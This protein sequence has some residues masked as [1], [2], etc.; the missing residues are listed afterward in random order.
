MPSEVSSAGANSNREPTVE[1]LQR[2][3]AEARDQQSATREILGVMAISPS[4]A[5]PVF[6]AIARSARRLCDGFRS[7]VYGFDGTLIHNVAHDN[8]SAEGV[9]VLGRVYPRPPSRETQIA[10]AILEGRVV[11]VPDMDASGVPEQS[12]ALARALG[13]RSILAVPMLK[14]GKS[15]GA[16]AIVRREAGAFSEGQIEVV[17][18][19]AGEAVIA[20]ENT[21][22]FQAEQA[23]KREV[24]EALE[25]QTA[26]SDVLAAIS[27]SKF[28]LQPVLQSV[29]ETAVRLCRAD[30]A[31]IY[32]FEEGAYRF[33]AG[34][35]PYRQE[36]LE[37]ERKE[38]IVPGHGTL[39]GRTVLAKSPVQIADALADPSYQK[40]ADALV[41]GVRSM[42]GVPLIRNE[43]VVGVVGLVRSRV[44]PFSEREV[45]LV[46]AFADQ[47]VIAIE[48]TRL[49]EEVQAR[50]EE[51]QEALERQTATSEVLSAISSSHGALQPVF[52]SLLANAVRLCQAK[53]GNLFIHEEGTFRHVA[54]Y[55]APA[56]FAEAR[57][58]NPVVRPPPRGTLA[59]IAATKEAQ[60][61]PD[62]RT[63]QAYLDG[64]P[65]AIE[66]ADAAGARTLLGVPILKDNEL[67]GVI[68][69]YRQEVR[70]FTA[71]QIELIKSFANQAVIAI[72][73]TRLFEAERA[74]KRELQES[75]QQQTATAEV[76][77]SISRSVFDL[78]AVLDALVE[79]AAKLC[80]GDDVSILRLTGNTL[81]RVA[82][83]GSM[84]A[85]PAYVIPVSRGTVAGRSVIERRPIDV[86][87]LQ[88]EVDTYP[89]GSA[90]ARELGHRTLLVVPLLREG[91]PL[92]AIT[93]RR[94]RVEPFSDKQIELVATFADQAVIAIENT[95]LFE[96]VQE[97]TRELQQSLEYQT[98]TSDVLG[99]ISRSPSEL[100][101]VLDVI[102]TTA[103]KLC[104]GFDA[105]I[106]LRDGDKLRVGAH[107]GGIPLDFESMGLGR[108]WITGR[109]VLDRQP[110][111]VHDLAS[112]RDQF[113]QG[114]DLH[115]RHGHRTGLAVP[116]MRDDQAIG[117]F[118]IRRMDVRPFSQKQIALLQTFADQ[119]VIAIENTR[120]FEAE[121]ASK[122]ELQESL[123]YQ[124]AGSEV[125]NVISRSPNRLQPV[126]DVIAQ[127]ASRLCGGEYAIVTRYDGSLIQLV[128]QHNPR[129]GAAEEAARLYP[130]PADPKASPG[131]RAI[132]TGSLVHMPDVEKE[133]LMGSTL[134]TYRR[135][136]A[137]AILSVP[138]LHRGQPIGGISVSRATPGPFSNRQIALLRTF[139]D[140][141][142]I[143]IE[144]ARLFEEVQ[145][146]TREL[147]EALEQQTATADVLKVISRSALDV[148]KVLDALVE[149]AARLC[150]AYDAAILQAVGDS[151]R[152]VAHYGQIPFSIPVG[153]LSLPLVR[154]LIT[155]RAILDRR[156]IQIADILAEGDEFPEGRRLALQTGFRTA[157]AVPLVHA[158]E[159]I[160]VIFIRR[161][162]VRPFTERQIE[163]VNTFADQAVIAIENTRLFEEVQART[164]ELAKTVED[165]EIASQHKSQ[166]VANMSHELRTPLAAILGYAELM[167]EGF[168][169]PLGQ[170]SL[171]ALTR[172]RS[173]GKH[174]LGLINTVL[175]VA[176]IESGQFTL[177][178]AEYAI[179]SVVETVRS[180]TESLAQHKRLAFKTEIARPL[181]IGLGD[182][183]RLT[184][185]LLNLVGNAI[186][187]T[188]AGEVRVTAKAVNRHFAISVTDTGPG[189][190]DEERTRIFEQFHQIDNSSTKAKGGTGLGL[191]IAKQIVE[192]HGGRI[193][194]ES[195]V[196]EG[197]TFQM[198]LPTRAEFQKREP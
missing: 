94:N 112:A 89:E 195:T 141:A 194:V 101:P 198:E 180:A 29:V 40:K 79:S 107:H 83:C 61:V 186:K 96:E 126:F 124:T 46:T 131:S 9:A 189:I 175:D 8:W 140:Q 22:L 149:S 65:A 120:L 127:N 100:Q 188:D 147:Q 86:A 62:V 5:Q 148:Q 102:V 47:A 116:L 182:E 23:S 74:S 66:L 108:G 106:L 184:Q 119:A 64:D 48:N 178:M 160:G 78:Q 16:I 6:D 68:A 99:V 32:R 135:I 134:A 181:P 165:L 50:T 36:Y 21:R 163:L 158:G 56:A 145:A 81:T 142:V 38:R 196:G 30:H 14:G 190:P 151:L 170:K 71:K 143:A 117:A 183:Q 39:V 49:F 115:L 35:G 166:F 177:N 139:A 76:L 2:R 42:L 122:R 91:T 155:G 26:T 82:H 197:S 55:G 104:E 41:G 80:G 132:V 12:L 93:L 173:N 123:E 37:V 27:R 69:V 193:W 172:I 44:E 125:L 53:F 98:A 70:P 150:D 191:A 192:M 171:D 144:N 174:L 7:A 57:R 34:F 133:E 110:V 43:E 28:D 85:P 92:G 77:K 179:E 146:R 54:L 58:R 176:K 51:L 103:A 97:R 59:R 52:E 111:H 187:F 75:L 152:G 109:A 1:E 137:R 10:Q 156:T 19:F 169:E 114:H 84:K 73:N 138:M 168:Y 90:I 113:P 20:I 153:Q 67:V 15:I 136:S 72:E 95:R 18:T 164:R 128:A 159:A 87:D 24:Q 25:Y 45:N 60:T 13:Y 162:E 3:L 31:M 17:K 130:L 167:Q 105:T 4:D 129:P 118:M 88:S 161:T 154:G 157:L 121:Q 185:V 11:H 63:A 33:A